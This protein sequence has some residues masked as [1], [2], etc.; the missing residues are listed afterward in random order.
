MTEAVAASLDD[1]LQRVAEFEQGRKTTAITRLLKRIGP[2]RT[3][4]AVYKRLGPA[5]DPWLMRKTHGQLISRWYGLPALLLA[6]T[7]AKSGQRRVQP[8]MY[9][10]DGH[11][12]A[13][14]GTN[15]G[16]TH[17]P[18][19]TGN[20]LAHPEAEVEVGPVTLAVTAELAD[21]ETWQRLWPNFVAVYP[22]YASYL[23]R[24][25]GRKP[26]MFVLQPL[27]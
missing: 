7:G 25:G 22:G 27:A 18:A 17:H 24:T 1:K 15:F 26:R 3:F 9:I 11:D 23:S 21:S 5:V 13:I 10:R 16:Q 4:A 12:F 20:L 6:T 19:W 2:T 8:L 14:V